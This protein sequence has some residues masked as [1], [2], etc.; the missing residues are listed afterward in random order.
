L[1]VAANWLGGLLFLTVLQEALQRHDVALTSVEVAKG[2]ADNVELI[3]GAVTF[4]DQTL[5]PFK[6]AEERRPGMI[7]TPVDRM[8]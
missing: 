2:L 8:K 6:V 1:T 4:V 3:S 5:L 7:P